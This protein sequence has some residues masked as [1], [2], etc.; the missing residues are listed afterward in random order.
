MER[1]G[2]SSASAR[3]GTP[4]AARAAP[5]CFCATVATMRVLSPRYEHRRLAG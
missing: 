3:S 1:R 2:D 5:S 4:V